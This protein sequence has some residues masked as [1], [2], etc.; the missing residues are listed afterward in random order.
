MP[1]TKKQ[2]DIVDF[3]SVRLQAL[4]SK[5]ASSGSKVASS[6]SKVASS[7]SK[8]ASSS[9]KVASSSSKVASSVPKV[10]SSQKTIIRCFVVVSSKKCPLVLLPM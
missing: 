4:V 9:S 10:A 7:G 3:C 5:V 8:V 2:K 6:S 1:L